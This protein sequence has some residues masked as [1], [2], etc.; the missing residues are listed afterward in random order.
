MPRRLVQFFGPTGCAV[1]VS[2]LRRERLRDGEPSGCVPP[3]L[4]PEHRN[5]YLRLPVNRVCAAQL[6]FVRTSKDRSTRMRANDLS[7]AL[8]GPAG[9]CCPN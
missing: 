4:R 1:G 9:W 6:H 5:D 7:I 3:K 8:D 2:G